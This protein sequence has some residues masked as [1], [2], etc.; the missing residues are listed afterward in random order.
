MKIFNKTVFTILITLS[1]M[2]FFL[3]GYSSVENYQG[4]LPSNDLIIQN[5]LML[6]KSLSS[7]NLIGKH[8]QQAYNQ[9]QIYFCY[10]TN[11]G[12]KGCSNR[13]FLLQ[14]D[15]GVWILKTDSGAWRIVTLNSQN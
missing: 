14:L 1:F 13:V 10:E 2:T 6:D 3:N 4:S 15:T 9:Y 12:E 8:F 5:I 7:A 11:T